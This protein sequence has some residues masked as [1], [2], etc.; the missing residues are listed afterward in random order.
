MKPDIVMTW[1]W[2]WDHRFT[3]PGLLYDEAHAYCYH[4]EQAQCKIITWTDD[5]HGARQRQLGKSSSQHLMICI[6]SRWYHD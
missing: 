1:L 2:F 4:N 6:L 5:A 3:A